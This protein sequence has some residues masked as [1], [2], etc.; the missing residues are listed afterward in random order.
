M[1]E[2]EVTLHPYFDDVDDEEWLFATVIRTD[3]ASLRFWVGSPQRWDELLTQRVNRHFD[4]FGLAK[5]YAAQAAN[6][7]VNI[8]H[9]LEALYEQDGSA[10][11]GA[12]L[13]ELAASRHAAHKNSW[14]TAAYRAWATS[15]WFC[16]GGFR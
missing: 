12:H 9:H 1:A 5:L 2:N 15:A 7:L 13:A 4:A 3:P 16:E 8:R 10:G 11:V 6:E 14:Q